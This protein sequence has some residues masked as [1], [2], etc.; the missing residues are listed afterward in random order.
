VQLSPA[1][2]YVVIADR[3]V[4]DAPFASVVAWLDTAI[5]AGAMRKHDE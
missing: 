3:D 2:T 1:T 4:V 5:R